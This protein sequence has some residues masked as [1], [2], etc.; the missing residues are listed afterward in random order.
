MITADQIFA[1]VAGDY[2]LQSHWL[3]TEKT[4]KHLAAAIH[5]T[6]YGLPF[7]IAFWPSWS[8]LVVI[9]GTHFVIDRWR[10]ARFVVWLKNFIAPFRVV[11]V[12]SRDLVGSRMAVS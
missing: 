9:V 12:D 2:I 5:A 3:A 11:K 10:L 1:H 4:R 8:A 7:L 6:V